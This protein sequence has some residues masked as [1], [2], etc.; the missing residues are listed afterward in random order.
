M[1]G[2]THF[3]GGM[4]ALAGLPVLLATAVNPFRPWHFVSFAVFGTA[5]ILLYAASTLFH[6]LP[7]SRVGIVRLRKLDHI[8]IFIFIAATYTPFCLVPFRGPFGWTML[9]CIWAI[10]LCGSVFKLYWIHVPKWLCLS[11]YF[12]AGWFSLAGTGQILRTLQ[13]GAIFSLLVGGASY[14]LGALFY[15][16]EKA[17]EPPVLFGY[18][19]AVHLFVILGSC[20]H[21]WVMYRYITA[22]S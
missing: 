1:S 19:E 20:A 15:A 22:F 13:P 14:C 2:L 11:L 21:F 6:W 7:A 12:F 4:M 18:H 17:D 16:L 3:V 8:M 10:A 5:M 9:G